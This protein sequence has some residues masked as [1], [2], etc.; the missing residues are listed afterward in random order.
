[1]FVTA[2]PQVSAAEFT[3]A[4]YRGYDNALS[5]GEVGIKVDQISSAWLL[6]AQP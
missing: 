1:M 2:G 3:F 4:Q 5:L 6:L